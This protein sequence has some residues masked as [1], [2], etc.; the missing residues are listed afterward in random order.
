MLTMA[1]PRA[2]KVSK[3]TFLGSPETLHKQKTLTLH[4][5]V[6]AMSENIYVDAPSNIKE[7]TSG[8]GSLFFIIDNSGS[9]KGM[10][11]AKDQ[12]GSRFT[13]TSAL[14]DTLYTINPKT[15][16]G[17][18]IFLA[19]LFFDPQDDPIFKK[20]ASSLNGGAYI[21][22][23][24]LDS[25]Y[26][27]LRGYD[28]LKKYLNTDTVNQIIHKYVDVTYSPTNTILSYGGTNIT[29]GFEAAKD[30][31][32]ESKYDKKNQ[33]AIFFSDGEA[34]SPPLD[35]EKFKYVQGID[36]PTTFTIY[37]TQQSV[38]L[39]N[40]NKM[41]TNIKNNGY[42]STNPKSNLW[43]LATGHE[44]LMKLL[45][46]NVIGNIIQQKFTA[47]PKSVSVNTWQKSSIYD[48]KKF[49]FD[50][51]FPLIGETT[52][53]SYTIP[54]TITYDTIIGKDT[55]TKELK[56]TTAKYEYAVKIKPNIPL[57]DS[58]KLEYW[59]RT[60]NYLSTPV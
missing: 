34:T 31:M 38:A 41:T 5:E 59:D 12:W 17:I 45:M 25:L 35:P 36:V 57:P 60:I 39:D 29:L 49:T 51:L 27:G 9:M 24:T 1:Y 32:K 56:D 7:L 47:T 14:L 58:I 19:D 6:V 8:G 42:S 21:P 37:F 2:E 22:L 11:M 20:C 52:E 10:G 54:Y 18:G 30:A 28:I 3:F 13:V 53:F 44:K 50:T 55:I 46:E 40:L 26:N 48:G 16:V 33:F 43:T 15:Q 4:E 23:L